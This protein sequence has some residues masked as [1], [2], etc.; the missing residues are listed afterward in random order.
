VTPSRCRVCATDLFAEPLLRYANMPRVAQFFPDQ[1]TVAADT[2]LDLDVW[3]CAGCGLIQLRTEPVPYYKEVVRAA[4][5]SDE[6]RAF[7]AGQFGAFLE[8]FSLGGRKVIEVGCGRGEYLS[9]LQ[10]AGAD[11]FGLE[12][13]AAAVAAVPGRGSQRIRGLRRQP[14]HGAR[15]RAVRCVRDSQLPRALPDPNGAL[16][17]IHRNLSKGAS[18]WSRS[19]TST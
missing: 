16:R 5:L 8:R 3:Q 9:V 17:G 1:S 11:A 19:R 10:A 14:R 18:G 4:G 13:S 12:Y 7:R 2:G 6:M 15:R